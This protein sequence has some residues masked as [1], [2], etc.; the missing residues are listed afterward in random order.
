MKF[1]KAYLKRFSRKIKGLKGTF[2]DGKQFTVKSLS[3]TV[4][5]PISTYHYDKTSTA[6]FFFNVHVLVTVEATF[7][8]YDLQ[9]EALFLERISNCESLDKVKFKLLSDSDRDLIVEQTIGENILDN[10]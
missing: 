9:I 8:E 3:Q 7:M 10:L 2:R 4:K 6:H 1:N 5:N